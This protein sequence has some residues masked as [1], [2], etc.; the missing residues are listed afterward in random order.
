M[1]QA[2]EHEAEKAT[3]CPP[4]LF[5]TMML[6]FLDARLDWARIRA[7]LVGTL[8]IG[9]T[10][11]LNKNQGTQLNGLPSGA[12]ADPNGPYIAPNGLRYR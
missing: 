3:N 1:Q 11:H 9:L 10:N 12:I 4:P 6:L 8:I 5:T 2:C 7:F